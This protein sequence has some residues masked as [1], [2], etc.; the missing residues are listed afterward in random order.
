M[1]A[2]RGV[3]TVSVVNLAFDE[4]QTIADAI[5]AAGGPYL[6]AYTLLV[7]RH[8]MSVRTARTPSLQLIVLPSC[9]VRGR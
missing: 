8:L 1:A 3:T 5:T 9:L 2:T 4:A 7:K 6:A